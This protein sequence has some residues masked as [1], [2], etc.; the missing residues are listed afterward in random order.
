MLG[1]GA[2]AAAAKA[3]IWQAK[4]QIGEMA[5][6]RLSWH[7]SCENGGENGVKAAIIG[8]WRSKRPAYRKRRSYLKP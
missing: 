4:S 7:P 3:A 5:A 2:A 6:R 1:S 8:I